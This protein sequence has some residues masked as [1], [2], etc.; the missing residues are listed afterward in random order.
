MIKYHNMRVIFQA[1]IILIADRPS[2]AVWVKN[3]ER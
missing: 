3:N 1:I 2:K